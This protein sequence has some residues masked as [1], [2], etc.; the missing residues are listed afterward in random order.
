MPKLKAFSPAP[1]VR[2]RSIRPLG[3]RNER[4]SAGSFVKWILEAER[5]I[6]GASGTEKKAW[7]KAKLDSIIM[8]PPIAEEISDFIISLGVE[9]AYAGMRSAEL[10]ISCSNCD[11]LEDE[12]KKCS[13]KYKGLQTRY[14][15]LKDS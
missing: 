13:S 4:Q 7:V 8:L 1:R 11:K 5:Q 2:I 12:L 15:K 10:D 9:L 14:K 3:K 6:P